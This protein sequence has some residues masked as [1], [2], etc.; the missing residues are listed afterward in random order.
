MLMRYVGPDEAV[1]V[2]VAGTEIGVVKQGES[3]VVPDE[4]A[5]STVWP[6]TL[7]QD[8]T[9]KKTASKKS[10]SAA[11]DESAASSAEKSDK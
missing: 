9:E 4:I 5:E 11:S 1:R 2:V 10:T 3:I 6:D 8:G 7:W